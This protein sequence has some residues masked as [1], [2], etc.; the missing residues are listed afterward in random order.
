MDK[1]TPENI[2]QETIERLEK[3]KRSIEEH[4]YNYHVLD[5]DDLSP[6]A[7]DSLKHE[8]A[9]IE[10][11][12]PSLITPDS[13]TQRVAGEPLPFFEKVEHKVRQ[14]SFNDV[15]TEDELRAF[16][17][18]V[19]RALEREGF[20]ESSPT[21]TCELKIDGLKIVLEYVDGRLET[22]ATRGNGLVGENVTANVRTIQSVPIVLRES[23][24]LIAEGEVL[25]TKSEFER[26][27]KSRE[28]D[29]LEPFKNPRNIAAGSVR[30]LDPKLAAERNLDAFIYDIAQF[31]GREIK[32]QIEGLETLR[33]LG[34]K[35]NPN[36]EYVHSIEGAIDYW[37]RWQNDSRSLDYLV[38]GVVV[39]VNEKEYQEALG[40]TGKAPRFAVAFKFP[41]E[42][43]TTR[44]LDIVFQVGRTG[45]ITPVAI[46][47]PAEVAGTT[48]ARATLHNEDYINEKDLRIGDTVVLQKA[49]DIIPEVVQ[50]LPELRTGK[51]RPFVFPDRIPE[52]GGD[53]RIE[54]VPGQAAYR[55]VDRNSFALLKRELY[56]FVSKKAF[57]IEHVGP[58]N[59]DLLLE[60]GVIATAP[61]IFELERGDLEGLPRMGERSITNMLE[62]IDRARQVSLARLLYALSIDLVGEETAILIAEKYGSLE[63]VAAASRESL[64][65]IP[66]VGE[67]VTQS[68]FD[69]FQDKNNQQ[70]LERLLREIKIESP[71]T[72]VQTAGFFTGK[73]VVLTGSLE[74]FTREEVVELIRSE[75]G[76]VS[77][78]VSKR[79]DFVIVGENPGSK[80]IRAEELGIEILR[81]DDLIR[82]KSQQKGL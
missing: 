59:I 50:S 61:D 5:D 21:Y 28:K 3:L 1:K 41:A 67:K 12:Y 52:C 53:G 2:P 55:C 79:T 66:G 10:E 76:S 7:L 8:L 72:K 71:K 30:Q 20:S 14:W 44:I 56:H 46:L 33:E 47:E 58:K 23:V 74:N 65:S 11:K 27:N 34:L 9:L 54:R 25:M 57:D 80:L 62:A 42:Q 45:V 19:K 37:K 73:T 70:M 43:V 35:V 40:Y 31:E 6:E 63:G 18:R 32:T 36:F 77:G 68:V 78:S 69:W 4:R 48:V 75:G 81:E 64:E 38:D 49:G 60:H 16:D 15:F 26:Q 24:S 82:I 39:K 22:A 17:E 51:E 29:G 13:P